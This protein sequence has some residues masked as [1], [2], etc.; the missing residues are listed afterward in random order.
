M[1]CRGKT[2][3]RHVVQHAAARSVG[4]VLKKHDNLSPVKYTSSSSPSLKQQ[5]NKNEQ[6][7]G[8]DEEEAGLGSRWE[9]DTLHRDGKKE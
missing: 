6:Q 8:R 1:C 5:K 7:N 4:Q 9:L 3:H 2:Q